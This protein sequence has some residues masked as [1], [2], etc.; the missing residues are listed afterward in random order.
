MKNRIY[1][2]TTFI[3]VLILIVLI[4]E[5]IFILELTHIKEFKYHKITGVVIKNNYILIVVDKQERKL[6]YNSKK[7]YHK[8]NHQ[9][10]EIVEDRGKV[11][12][13]NKKNYYELVIKTNFKNK[14]KANDIYEIVIPKEKF[15]LIE[16]FKTIWEGEDNEHN[17]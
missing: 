13:N 11:L 8:D 2:R 16:I 17:R 15:R 6:L 5:I 3:K 7:L 9:K 12:N 10:Y 1:E 14:Y 4:L